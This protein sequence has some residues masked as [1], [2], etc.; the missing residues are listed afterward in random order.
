MCPTRPTQPA[1]FVAK[2]APEMDMP[3]QMDTLLQM[4]M[5]MDMPLDTLMDMQMEA[6]SQHEMARQHALVV[7][8]CFKAAQGET[9]EGSMLVV[10]LGWQ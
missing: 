6:D 2:K 4:D 8:N 3:T 9:C 1:S 7:T 5:Q 10:S